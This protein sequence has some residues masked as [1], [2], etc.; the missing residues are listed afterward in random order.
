MKHKYTMFDIQ[1]GKYRCWKDPDQ[2]YLN[3]FGDRFR[4]KY[5]FR[6]R[7]PVVYF[8]FKY[9]FFANKPSDSHIL[10]DQLNWRICTWSL[11]WVCSSSVSRVKC[12]LL[13]RHFTTTLVSPAAGLFLLFPFCSYWFFLYWLFMWNHKNRTVNGSFCFTSWSTSTAF[14]AV[15]STWLNK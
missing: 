3:K 8:I 10:R 9:L 2:L 11:I 14:A 1:V 6:L 7:S 4:L 13:I 15:A 12:L 5:L